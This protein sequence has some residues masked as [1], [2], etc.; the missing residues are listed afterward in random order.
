[1]EATSDT[2]FAGKLKSRLQ[3]LAAD[4]DLA[5][6]F[7]DIEVI[8]GDPLFAAVPISRVI[9]EEKQIGEFLVFSLDLADYQEVTDRWGAASAVSVGMIFASLLSVVVSHYLSRVA[10]ESAL[11]AVGLVLEDV[12]VPFVRLDQRDRI[13]AYNG[14]FIKL[15][16]NVAGREFR[17]LL[18]SAESLAKYEDV[19]RLRSK[20]GEG[21]DVTEYNVD[22]EMHDGVRR[23]RIVSAAML[24]NREGETP[25]TY[26]IVLESSNPLFELPSDRNG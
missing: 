24:N 5:S 10:A 21:P 18:A 1:M 15:F 26:G 2:P 9:K 14:E 20:S 3:E 17:S 4:E 11:T 19:Q 8:P 23:C 16:G 7:G 13:V 12:G 6:A 22:L 25:A